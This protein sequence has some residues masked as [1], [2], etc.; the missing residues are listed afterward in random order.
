MRG[1]GVWLVSHC[2]RERELISHNTCNKLNGEEGGTETEK[3]KAR[4]QKCAKNE[5]ALARPLEGTGLFLLISELHIME[6][7]LR[8]LL[9]GWG[10]QAGT[11]AFA[12]GRQLPK[13]RPQQP[14]VNG[15]FKIPRWTS[16]NVSAEMGLSPQLP[17]G[18]GDSGPRAQSGSAGGIHAAPRS[19]AGVLC[20]T[21]RNEGR[22]RLGQK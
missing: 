12:W 14:S 15:G 11:G 2:K 5:A 6:K 8:L 20:P 13:K 10:R 7:V 4:W 16:Q 1:L 9:P 17:M 22:G 18:C 21:R 3:N 19:E